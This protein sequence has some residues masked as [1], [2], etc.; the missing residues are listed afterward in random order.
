MFKCLEVVI[1][2]Y[3]N[4]DCEKVI[5]QEYDAHI[6]KSFI[7]CIVTNLMHRVHKKVLQAIE[8]CYVDALSSFDLLNSSI[9]L[10]YISCAVRALPL[11]L[12][13]ISDELEI[14]L[15]KVMNLLKTILLPYAF[16]GHGPQIRLIVFLTDDSNAKRNALNQCCLVKGWLE[17]DY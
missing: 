14:I 11:G 5:L 15:E 10:F 6:R 7:L 8:L 9:T 12:F 4:S 16:F 13:I 3:N 1:K 17:I 2:N